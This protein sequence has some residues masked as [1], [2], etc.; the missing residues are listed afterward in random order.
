MLTLKSIP[1]SRTKEMQ[2]MAHTLITIGSRL[3][4]A[5]LPTKSIATIT[6]PRA[7]LNDFMFSTTAETRMEEELEVY[8]E[9]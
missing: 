2:D 1:L 5:T 8:Q 6:A 9:Y 7:K 3:A 4:E